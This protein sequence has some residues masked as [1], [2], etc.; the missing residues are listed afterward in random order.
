MRLL[1]SRRGLALTAGVI[2]LALCLVRPGAQG[3][4]TRI[5]SRISSALG[6]PVEASSVSLRFLPRPGFELKQFVVRNDARFGAEPVLQAPEVAAVLRVGPLLRGKFEIA[7]LS[8]SEPSLNLVRNKDGSWN[9]AALVEKTGQSVPASGNK[10]S[11]FPYIEASDARVNFKVGQEKKPFALLNADFALWQDPDSAW[12]LRLKAQPVRAD[13]NLSDTGTVKIEGS[14]KPAATLRQAPVKFQVS[15]TNA[16]LGQGTKLLLGSD[17][18]WRGELRLS[19]DLSGTPDNLAIQAEALV[20]DFRRYDIATGTSL[21]LGAKCGAHY[22]VSTQTFG[23]VA[24]LAPVGD[25]QIVLSGNFK[26]TEPIYDLTLSAQSIPLQSL[27]NLASKIKRNLPQDLTASGNLEADL[28]FSRSSDGETGWTGGGQAVNVQ[29]ASQTTQGRVY[30]DAI[31]F[32]VTSAAALSTKRLKDRVPHA[33]PHLEVGPVNLELPR[34]GLTTIKGVIDRNGYD[35]QLQGPTDIPHLLR[36]AKT[37][38]FY[39]PPMVAEGQADADLKVAGRWAGFAAPLV[40]G[41]LQL[42]AVRALVRGIKKPLEVSSATVELDTDEVRALNFTGQFGGSLWRGNAT[43]PRHCDGGRVCPLRFDL[44]TEE[45]HT[46]AIWRAFDGTSGEP[47]YKALYSQKSAPS[48]L[49]TIQ[50]DGRVSSKKMSFPHLTLTQVSGR[51][52]ID[53]RKLSITHLSAEALGGQH[54]GEWSADFNPRPPVYSGSGTLDHALLGHLSAA[55]NDDWVQ[56]TVS[57]TYRVTAAGW[58]LSEV[59][60]SAVG[61]AGWE[62]RNGLLTH[63]ILSQNEPLRFETFSGKLLLRDGEFEVVGSKLQRSDGIYQV[64]GTASMGRVL[65]LKL[66]REGGHGFSVTGPLNDPHVVAATLPD[67]Q[68]ALKP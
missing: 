40:S 6:R 49:A 66:I 47:W 56:G 63:V 39:A 38:G 37:A 9:V 52:K 68:A 20:N 29:L 44:Y 11:L 42:R 30:L 12:G 55:M 53:D 45:I 8:F 1:R 26:A 61:E 48:F 32:T 4:R 54:I 24:C 33:A 27:A 3:M 50:A 59:L 16:Q 10:P 36:A 51:L 18:G 14:W 22:S 65:N 21:R 43:I 35:F 34:A 23:N 31:P 7:R 62:A 41:R 13:F 15:W 28:T 25:G 46:D 2:F 19:A 67:T 17:K 60:K 5:V 58:K 64:S 57:G